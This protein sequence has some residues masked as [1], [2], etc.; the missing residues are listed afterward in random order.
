MAVSLVGYIASSTLRT[1]RLLSL[2]SAWTA[3][4]SGFKVR[5]QGGSSLRSKRDASQTQGDER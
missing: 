5:S 2:A 3:W 4:P 1:V